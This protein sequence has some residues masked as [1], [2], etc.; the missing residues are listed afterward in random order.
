MLTALISYRR[1]VSSP[2]PSPPAPRPPVVDFPPNGAQREL[3]ND[4]SMSDIRVHD[5]NSNSAL[6]GGVGGGGGDTWTRHV[7]DVA[8]QDLAGS[9]GQARHAVEHARYGSGHRRGNRRG[10]VTDPD[11]AG[12]GTEFAFQLDDG[13]GLP[14]GAG[15]PIDSA[16]D[17]M[18]GQSVGEAEAVHLRK[19]SLNGTSK[20][21]SLAPTARGS[22]GM[23]SPRDEIGGGDIIRH[24]DSPA[25]LQQHRP[26]VKTSSCRRLWAVFRNIDHV[27][28]RSSSAKPRTTFCWWLFGCVPCRRICYLRWYLFWAG[29]GRLAI[30]AFHKALAGLG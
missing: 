20:G 4:P 26:Q 24:R 16:L 5:S 6:G 13:H 7:S 25:A 14:P 30:L 10:A 22:A 18:G 2:P 17:W 8:S 28:S 9:A 21:V 15:P 19:R 29:A 3:G 11:M 23:K 1:C 12:E 27:S